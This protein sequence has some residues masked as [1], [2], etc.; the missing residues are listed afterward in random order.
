M[1]RAALLLLLVACSKTPE[2]T[3]DPAPAV[4]VTSSAKPKSDEKEVAWDA[5]SSW[6]SMPNP[7]TMRKATYKVGEDTEMTVSTGVP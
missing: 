1:K 6:Q 3:P 7:T 5:P 4:T 2:P